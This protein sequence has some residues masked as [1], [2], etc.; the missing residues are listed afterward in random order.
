[1]DIQVCMSFDSAHRLPCV[2]SG[3][4][5]G[6]LHGHTFHVE[7]FVSGDISSEY[8]WVTDFADVKKVVKPYLELLDHAYLNDIEGLAN[9]TSEHI[10]VWLWDR[11]KPQLPGLSK[12]V[13][14]ETPTSAA[15]YTGV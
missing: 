8:G 3:H 6:N 2:P 15:S 1:M 4:K 11:I 12:V 14:K 7:F 9:P 5:C 13:V 10:A